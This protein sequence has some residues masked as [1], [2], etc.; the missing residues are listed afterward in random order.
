MNKTTHFRS[1]AWER[2]FHQFEI[3]KL[4]KQIKIPYQKTLFVFSKD[5]S[6]ELGIKNNKHSNLIIVVK[7]KIL[8]TIYI[9]EDLYYYLKSLKKSKFIII[10]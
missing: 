7:E 3:D 8:V 5:K 1:R 4:M 10:N 6:K 2:G 9:V